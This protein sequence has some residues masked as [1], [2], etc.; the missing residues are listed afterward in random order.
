MK[1]IISN[2]KISAEKSV[3]SVEIETLSSNTHFT[4]EMLKICFLKF[5]HVWTC[6]LMTFFY[7]HNFVVKQVIY[8]IAFIILVQCYLTKFIYD[9]M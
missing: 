5:V 1:R 8:M 4:L 9:N 2:M 6:I 3:L 7:I